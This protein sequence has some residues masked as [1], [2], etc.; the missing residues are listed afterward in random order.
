MK[1]RTR[2]LSKL[3]AMI[4]AIAIAAAWPVFG[5]ESSVSSDDT[6]ITS[7]KLLS[8]FKAAY[9]KAELNDKGDVLLQ[10]GGMKTIVQVDAKKKTISYISVWPMK[11]SSSELEKLRFVNKLNDT[12]ILVRFCMPRPTTLWCDYQMS[13][14]AGLSPQTLVTTYRVF[15]KVVQGAMATM[16][17][18][19]IVGR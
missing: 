14:E 4:S 5:D 19:D 10:E 6:E 18:D 12:L 11:E 15:A 1:A 7:A 2:T 16:D 13:F 8:M 9:V 17:P 3:G